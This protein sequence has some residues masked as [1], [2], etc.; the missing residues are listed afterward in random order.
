MWNGH[1]ILS[2]VLIPYLYLCFLICGYSNCINKPKINLSDPEDALNLTNIVSSNEILE[3]GVST[4]FASGT[5]A[6][7]N[8][9][10]RKFLRLRRLLYFPNGT[11]SFNPVMIQIILS[12]DVHPQPGPNSKQKQNSRPGQDPEENHSTSSVVSQHA[13]S[14]IKIA[15]LNI[16]SLKSREHRF[17]LQHTNEDHD[18]DI[19]TIS[20]TWL[21]STVDNQ[22]LQIPGF[23]LF[24]QD[25]GEHKSGGGLAVYIRDTF[26]ATLLEHASGISD[27]NFQQLWIKVQVR[28]CKSTFICSVYR[29]PDTTLAFSD[30]L[31]RSLLDILLHG[32]DVII[33]G[34][35]NCNILDDTVDSRTFK[36]LC[37]SFN[38]TQ[39][40]K[41][42]TR[43]GQLHDDDI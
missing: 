2:S 18:F 25:W 4:S 26:K 27:E 38:L 30:S 13:N 35:L 22:A 17:L 37:A 1:V 33:L 42:P 20:E 10:K 15:Q 31:S 14:C 7:T 24:R 39:L 11:E 36:E 43:I 5:K 40:V 9:I 16:R 29:P 8:T 41:E 21:A 34:V 23:V 19:F 12:G 3:N 6:A 32:N 28:H